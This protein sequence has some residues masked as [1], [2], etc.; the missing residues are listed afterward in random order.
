MLPVK[1]TLAMS[2]HEIHVS[3]CMNSVPMPVLH[4]LQDPCHKNSLEVQNAL[5]IAAPS[6]IHI[7][8]PELDIVNDA[9]SEF[10]RL[11][12]LACHRTN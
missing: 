8:S 2:K 6:S 11:A 12:A 4:G 9:I 10:V 7:R 5:A 3:C 1:F